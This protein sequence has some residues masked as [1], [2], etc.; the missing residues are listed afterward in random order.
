M[1]HIHIHCALPM[2]GFMWKWPFNLKST[3]FNKKKGHIEHIKFSLCSFYWT[4][5]A[6]LF[7]KLSPFLFLQNPKCNPANDFT[8]N[9]MVY[10]SLN[11]N[12]I[13]W[14]FQFYITNLLVD[15]IFYSM[16]SVLGMAILFICF[17]LWS[18]GVQ[19]NLSR[20]CF[21]FIF[22]IYINHQLFCSL[23]ICYVWGKLGEWF[24]VVVAD[25]IDSHAS[26]LNITIF[27]YFCNYYESS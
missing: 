21:A 26:L 10:F 14:I 16:S 2:K 8:E 5:C 12:L 23:K 3:P 15:E 7:N 9:E 17:P 22:C 13:S 20:F 25:K 1:L 11:K 6:L 18:F 4:S 27:Q 19:E 24:L